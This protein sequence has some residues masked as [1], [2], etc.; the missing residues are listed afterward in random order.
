MIV[1]HEVITTESG[2]SP[3]ASFSAMAAVPGDR[4]DDGRPGYPSA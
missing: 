4:S 3:L 2:S 1:M